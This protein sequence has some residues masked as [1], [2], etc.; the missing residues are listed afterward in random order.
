MEDTLEEM[1]TQGWP[2]L[3]RFYEDKNVA[4]YLFRYPWRELKDKL[5]IR[6]VP[7]GRLDER[8]RNSNGPVNRL[9]I[10]WEGTLLGAD[11]TDYKDVMTTRFRSSCEEFL[12]AHG[13]PG[14]GYRPG[15]EP[16]DEFQD[17]CGNGPQ[18]YK[19]SLD[20]LLGKETPPH[21]EPPGGPGDRSLSG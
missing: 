7:A 18:K 11:H 10:K 13:F 21:Q 15:S 1:A 19:S 6:A 5:L 9:F 14:K 4:K 17:F 8:Y 20:A 16:V 12:K 2:G 3:F